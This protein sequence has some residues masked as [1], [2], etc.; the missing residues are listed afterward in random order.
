MNEHDNSR[1]HFLNASLVTAVTALI[2][3]SVNAQKYT[4]TASQTEGPYYP[5]HQQF[6]KNSDMTKVDQRR[7]QAVGEIIIISGRIIDI[8]GQPVKDALIDIWQAD[9]NGRYLHDDAPE[10]APLDENFQ[11]WAQLKSDENGAYQVTTIIPGK[12][13]VT[14]Q[15]FRPP[16]IHFKVARRGLKELTTQMYFANNP[17]NQVDRLFL[18]ASPEEQNSIKVNFINGQG[19]FDIILDKIT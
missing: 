16:H 18:A 1:R 3:P 17:L 7:G 13:R 4:K 11:Y 15:W 9:K 2:A 14:E 10:S 12:Y 6:D 5:K 8:D 19:K